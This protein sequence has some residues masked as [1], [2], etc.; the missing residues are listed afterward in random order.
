MLNRLCLIPCI[1]WIMILASV[2]SLRL[3]P[4]AYANTWQQ[5]DGYRFKELN[6]PST[7]KPGFTSLSTN[8]TGVAF[9]NRL[10]KERYTTNQIYL[11]GSGVAA[12]DF[13]GDGWCDLF[14]SGLDSEN[15]LY[16]NLGNWKFEDVTAKARVR[17]KNIAS[18]GAAFADLNGNG[19][20][21]LIINSVGQG[22]WI[23]LN[24]GD[25]TFRA[26]RPINL[27]RGGMSMA[28]A[29]VDGDSDLDLYITNYRTSTIRDEPGTKL[30][31]RTVNG[32]PM[33]VGV[34][35]KSLAEANSVG[36]FTLKPNGKIIENGQA[37][38]LFL[39]DGRGKF[40]RV[41]FT[42]GA[43]LDEDGNPL[44]H[45]LY[46]WGLSAM[47][48]DMN[49][50][51]RPDLYVCND[52]ESPDRIWINQGA[53]KFKAIDRLAI[54]KSSHFSM[55]IDFSD[56]NRDGLDD[57]FVADML[58]RKHSL[59]H[60]QLSNRKPPNLHHGKYDDRPQYSY[61]TVFLN[62]GGLNYSEI[63]FHT[64]LA[65][66]EW[67]WTPVFM[68][69]DLDGYED[70]LITTGHPLDMQD[71]D[72]TNKAEELK[73]QKK[74]TPRELLN[75][76]FMFKPLVLKNLAFRNEG[77]L[78]FNE[79]SENWGFDHKG[80]SHGMALADFDNDGDL[81]VVVNNFNETA[82]I[83]RNNSSAPRVAISLKGLNK[84]THGIGARITVH[85]KDLV[86][87]Q[88]I[89]GGGRYLSSDEAKRTF[90][91]RNPIENIAITWPSGKISMIEHVQPNSLYEIDERFGANR[92]DD[93]KESPEPLFKDV[94]HLL[95]HTHF[96]REFDDFSRQ[97]LL[98]KKLSQEGPSAA[99]VDW[100]DDGFDDIAITSGVGGQ[101][102]LFLNNKKGGFVKP[103][104]MP[105]SN[106]ASRD[107]IGV[108]NLKSDLNNLFL[109]TSNY[110]DG[111]S[112]GSSLVSSSES[113]LNVALILEAGG[114]SYSAICSA[115]YDGDGD[116]DLFIGSRCIPGSY[117]K[118]SKS[119]LL[120]NDSSKYTIDYS[121]NDVCSYEGSVSSAIWTDLIGDH[122]PEL[123]LACDPGPITIFK[124]QKGKLIDVTAKLGFDDH[125][126]F[127]NSVSSGDFNGDGRMDL[128]CGNLGTNTE[129]E[130]YRKKILEWY[131]LDITG[132]GT[133][134]LFETYQIPENANSY[135]LRV[136]S[137]VL[138]AIPFL[139]D[140][141]PS[142][143]AYSVSTSK[144]L[145]GNLTA[146]FNSYKITNFES[147]LWLNNGENFEMKS[148]PI[149]AQI[150]PVFGIAVADF[151]LDGNEDVFLSQNFFG[152]RV[153][154]P[155]LDAGMGVVLIGDG[156]GGFSS[157]KPNK[158]GI[159]LRGDQRAA[160]VADFNK[161][162]KPDLLVTQ[163][164]GE[165]KLFENM[166][167]LRGVAIKLVGKSANPAA[168]GANIRLVNSGIA[169]P[170]REIKIGGG[171]KSQDAPRQLF[172]QD[173]Q[174]NTEV[175]VS[176]PSGVSSKTVIES[177]VTALRI[178]EP[179]K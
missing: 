179:E 23:L 7:G 142:Y 82:S 38:G 88:E 171:Y 103:K 27:R 43:F 148:L 176:W 44:D 60:T 41:P 92:N 111:L 8:Q 72:V 121:N 30:K 76:R 107:Q 59:R 138:K 24:I 14:F 63:G 10:S 132:G 75:F 161:D 17:G 40:T 117:P 54:R 85:T 58:S 101:F 47:F 19:R 124:N 109:L 79:H 64:G 165:T 130:L 48:R 163:N 62:R 32:T 178:K 37:D 159:S 98:P 127:W 6:V 126:G 106:T 129:Y 143:A 25:G 141:F 45:P 87:S 177:G 172:R 152:T 160:A 96:D 168:I 83:Y 74:R 90:A 73:K 123:V 35:G 11:N 125:V 12:G 146:N 112:I 102:T 150:S 55:G 2:F 110:E 5:A 26:T 29:D 94:S 65:A 93:R 170:M 89:T 155:R 3:E 57:F 66:T 145:L 9:F 1:A 4:N 113:K 15:K 154:F 133:Y 50:D 118:N 71:I 137:D 120:K 156:E 69:V 78:T 134:D 157:L 105:F 169:G 49:Q 135:P 115:D 67:S 108:I 80:I 139:P 164:S 100:N 97:L 95:K 91:A 99:W 68:D 53:G 147:V 84:N 20:L 114:S 28:I 16:R 13:D 153:G 131:I 86:Q 21:D 122:L 151:N 174:T 61:N 128:I 149:D 116:L 175:L 136:Y 31:G 52:F 46:E 119:I 42:D 18:T 166:S 51:G 77:N 81:D 70:F 162:G 39:N 140:R 158:S 104:H 167:P 56:I 22:T 36:R 173:D 34:N 144:Q 33:V